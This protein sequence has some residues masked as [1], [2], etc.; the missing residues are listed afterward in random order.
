MSLALPLAHFGQQPGRRALGLGL[1]IL[2]H[3]GLAYLLLAAGAE[4][5]V[6]LVSSAVRVMIVEDPDLVAP[7]LPAKAL[8]VSLPAPMAVPAPALVTPPVAPALAVPRLPTPQDSARALPP[9]P[10][11]TLQGPALPGI[12]ELSRAA[13][14]EVPAVDPGKASALPQAALPLPGLAPAPAS[15]QVAKAAPTGTTPIRSAGQASASTPLL[16]DLCPTTVKALPPPRAG[17]AGLGGM[18]LARATIRSGRVIRV[19]ILRSEPAGLFDGAVRTAMLQ[20]VCR[21]QGAVELLAE[22]LFEFKLAE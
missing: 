19:E 6:S 13:P 8:S 12:I 16:T 5:Q 22:Q 11:V 20:Y 3:L 9:A 2:A 7:Q 4:R 21:D 10:P 17:K 1:V 14:G 18:V 15:A